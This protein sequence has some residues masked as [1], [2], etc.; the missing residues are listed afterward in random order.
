MKHTA[1]VVL[2]LIFLVFLIQTGSAQNTWTVSNDPSFDAD[3][4]NIQ[5]AVDSA[6]AGD[7]IYVHGSPNPYT[8]FTID[9]RLHLIGAGYFKIENNIQDENTNSSYVDGNIAINADS[10]LIEGFL[11]LQATI[12][13]DN[14]ILRYNRFCCYTTCCAYGQIRFA[15]S[16]VNSFIYGNYIEKGLTGIAIGANIYNNIMLWPVPGSLY[17][18]TMNATSINCVVQNNSFGFPEVNNDTGEHFV[19]NCTFRNN[20]VNLQE[21]SMT[22]A[23]LEYNLFADDDVSINGVPTDSLGNGN[24]D[25][26]D[27]TTVWDATYPSSDA[28]FQLIGDSMTNPAIGAGING[29]DCGPYGGSSPY[30]I[31]GIVKVPTIYQ[32]LIPLIGDTTNM[33]SIRIRAKSN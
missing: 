14:V 26:I 20:I 13:A 31:A 28:R 19:D 33:L 9:K 22:N 2:Y 25:S 27:I 10:V 12:D 18:W 32:M 15:G 5:E 6:E 1:S 7:K 16:P 24:I 21:F 8:G 30:R 4:D 3:F 17:Y 29:E 23:T 11:L